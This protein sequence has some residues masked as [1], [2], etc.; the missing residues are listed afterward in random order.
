MARFCRTF[1][2]LV[3]SGVPILSAL[4]IVRDTAGN[5]V[6]A[7]AVDEARRVIR[8]GSLISPTL[9]KKKPFRPWRCR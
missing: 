7:D 2:S 3:R 8:E 6:I 4:E 9:K 1:G 5:A